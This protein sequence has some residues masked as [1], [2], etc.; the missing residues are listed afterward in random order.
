VKTREKNMKPILARV[1]VVI[2]ALGTLC[3]AQDDDPLARKINDM[4]GFH[5][6]SISGY[7]GAS[8]SAYPSGGVVLNESDTSA[9]G[10]L[11]GDV[12]YGGGVSLGWQ[13][14]GP[15]TNMAMSYSGGYSGM[16][17]Y[18][19]VNGLYQ[20]LTMNVSRQLTPKWTGNVGISGMDNTT[21]QFFFQ[22]PQMSTAVSAPAT[23]DDFAAAFG[24]GQ[25]SNSAIASML[26]GVPVLESPAQALLVGDRILSYSGTADLSYAYSSRLHFRISGF[27]GAGQMRLGGSTT[28]A[29]ANYVLPRSTSL[30]AGGGF[31]YSLSPRTDIGIDASEYELWNK[32]Q[33]ARGVNVLASLGRK[34]GRRWFLR[35]YGGGSQMKTLRSVAG[36]PDR[37]QIIGGGAL[38][39]K[40]YANTLAASYDRNSHNEL[41][42]AAG[43]DTTIP[44]SWN[45]QRPGNRWSMFAAFS[46]EQLRNATFASLSGWHALGGI[47]LRL[48][49]PV[50]VSLDYSHSRSVGTYTGQFHDFTADSL[51]LTLAWSPTGMAR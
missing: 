45:W 8:T 28:L 35:I 14:H 23:F 39:I 22:P 17:R 32:Y 41:G 2:T 16:V 20:S 42:F 30:T 26:T 49:P 11:G 10:A 37:N 38:G 27:S 21:A 29:A 31:T 24:V 1:A 50:T 36:I 47:S 34:M 19:D 18:S 9:I 4:R 6:Y 15:R 40:S 33:R 46:Q 13:H 5:I 43:T 3:F 25:F 44:A 51:R 48:A 12:S 7:A